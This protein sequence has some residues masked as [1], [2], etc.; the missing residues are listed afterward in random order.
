MRRIEQIEVLRAT[1]PVRDDCFTV[2]AILLG[3]EASKDLHVALVVFQHMVNVTVDAKCDVNRVVPEVKYDVV[4]NCAVLYPACD[5]WVVP[6]H[7]LN[8]LAQAID[9][10]DGHDQH[11]SQDTPERGHVVAASDV[12]MGQGLF[13]QVKLVYDTVIGKFGS[14]ARNPLLIFFH[15]GALFEISQSSFY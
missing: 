11:T 14:V 7:H 5:V 6:A 8:E 13:E 15:T 1:L 3:E 4:I 10:H 12:E 9:C 2:D